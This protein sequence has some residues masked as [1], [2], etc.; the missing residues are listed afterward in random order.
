MTI[1]NQTAIAHRHGC[2]QHSKNK[3]HMETGASFHNIQ[4]RK[5]KDGQFD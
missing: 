4:K 1:Y 2:Y 3:R 5:L